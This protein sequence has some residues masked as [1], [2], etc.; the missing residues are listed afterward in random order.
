[1]GNIEIENRERLTKEFWLMWAMLKQSLRSYVLQKRSYILQDVHSWESYQIKE[2]KGSLNE[3]ILSW[4][5][6]KT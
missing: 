2:R 5:R 6:G 3:E 1:M 4:V